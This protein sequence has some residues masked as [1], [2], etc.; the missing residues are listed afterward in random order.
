[1]TP[2]ERFPEPPT[3]RFQEPHYSITRLA[4][5]WGLSRQTIRRLVASQPGV[6]K[7]KMGPKNART[8]YS[9]PR[10]VAIRIHR[11]ITTT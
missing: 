7:V 4:S 1:M 10:S 2:T 6:L 5:Q 9:V 11:N 8:T 3:E